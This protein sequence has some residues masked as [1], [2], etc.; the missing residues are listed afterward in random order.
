MKSIFKSEQARTV[1]VEWHQRFRSKIPASTES[2]RVQTR[3]GEAHVLVGGPEH[4]PP[5]VIAHGALAS[6]AHVLRELAGLLERFRVYAVDVVGQSPMSADLRPSVANNDY[7]EWLRDVLDA[8]ELRRPF[9]IGVSWGGFVSLRL[10]ACAPERIERLVLLVPAGMVKSPLW[11]GFVKMGVPMTRFMM[12][13]TDANL[14]RFTAALLTTPDDDWK[15]YLG[16]AFRSYNMN[17]KVPALARPEELARFD[18]PV[19]VIGADQDASFPGAKVISRA[20]Q[21]FKGP[22]ETELLTECRHSPPTTEEF[23]RSNCERIARFLSPAETV[24][25]SDRPTA[26]LP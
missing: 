21:L 16:V 1:L 13:P 3:F 19:L 8:L 17:I 15:Q 5:L 26:A 12:S 10:A 2:R 4:A 14:E 9:V 20:K 7:G 25:R 11:D 22:L 24:S 23:R 18:A 6:S